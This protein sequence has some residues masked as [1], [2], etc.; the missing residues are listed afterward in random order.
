MAQMARDYHE[1]IQEK[2][3]PDEYGRILATEVVLEKCKVHLSEDEYHQLDK[4]LTENDIREALKLS[5]TGKSPGLDGLPYEFFRMLDIK[6]QQNKETAFDIMSLLAKLFTHIESYGITEGTN[7]NEGW[8]CPFYKKG[9][10]ALISNYRPITLLNTDYKLMTKAYSLRLMK[11]APSLIHPDQAGFM[12]G[13]KIEDQVKLAKFLLNYAE[14]AEED[15]IIIALDQEKAYDRINHNYLMRVLRH[16]RFPPRFYNTIANLYSNAKTVVI[17]NGMLSDPYIVLRG[18]RQGDPLSCLLFNLAIEPLACLIRDADLKGVKIPGTDKN[19]VVSL[20]A[21]DTTIYLSSRDSWSNLWTILDLWCAA[22]T[23]KFNENKT[24]ILPFGKQKYRASVALERRINKAQSEIISPSVRIVR[25]GET[26][27]ILGAWL[28]NNV[29]YL[30]PWPAT[31]DKIR[32]DLERWKVTE[33]T[34][35]G[36]RHIISMFVGGRSQYLTRV[37]G[38]PKDIEETLTMLIHVFLWD[39]KRARIS[40]NAMYSSVTQGGKQILNLAAR[41]EAID[42]WNLQSYLVQGPLQAY[43][44]YFV[45]LS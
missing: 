20:F 26:C 13:R 24:V 37:Q 10:K 5:K 31:V 36:K 8:L 30:T 16:M 22:S 43:W 39:G 9:D 19:L 33:P 18:V 11:V 23:A 35:E 45:D 17:I 32:N 21:D 42:L 7:F 15:G 41:N 29:T 38:M 3:L 44:C 40:D 14:V 28:G 6:F 1:A 2:D 4:D 34:L 25:D 12:K 27:R